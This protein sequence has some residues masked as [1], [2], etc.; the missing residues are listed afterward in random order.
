MILA[1]YVK[2]ISLLIERTNV[3]AFENLTNCSFQ[4][5]CGKTAPPNKAARF[6]S[7]TIEE[8]TAGSDSTTV[9]EATTGSDSTTV[10][11]AAA[12]SDSTTVEEAT[13]SGVSRTCGGSAIELL[14][15]GVVRVELECQA[16]EFEQRQLKQ[17]N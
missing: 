3:N 1:H 16:T 6:G 14:G 4:A 5:W 7:T 10:E 9:E 8:A 17:S 13:A 12:G 2:C 15:G 11:E